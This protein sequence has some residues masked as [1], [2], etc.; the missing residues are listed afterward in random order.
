[1]SHADESLCVSIFSYFFAVRD[2]DCYEQI[3]H[4]DC[5]KKDKQNYD[6]IDI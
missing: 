3:Y 1:M 5:P 2:D 4:A 6:K